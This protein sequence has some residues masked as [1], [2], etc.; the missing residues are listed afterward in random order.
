MLF[1]KISR[2][3]ADSVPFRVTTVSSRILTILLAV[4]IAYLIILLV[5]RI[6]EPRL[7]FFPN[8]PDRMAGN[9]HPRDLPVEDV[10][11][12]TSDGVKLH[13][14]WIGSNEAEYTFLA[15]HGN[16]S[17]I[18]NRVNV[19]EFLHSIPVNVLAVEYRGYGKSEGRPSERGMYLDAEAG[20]NYLS[21][22]KKTDPRKIISYG[23]SLG[24][25][26]AAQLAT[27]HSLEGVVLEAP[28]PS[29]SAMAHRIFPFLPGTS[30]VT[31]RQFDTKRALASIHAPILIVHCTRDPVVP[32]DMGEEVFSLANPPKSI[33]RVN[34][35]CHEE[36]S[37]VDP[38]EYRDA[39]NTFLDEVKNGEAEPK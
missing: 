4:L 16:A 19:Y 6:F 24:S 35:D 33:L 31:W 28:F 8:V 30:I 18:A 38:N 1:G 5:V 2:A 17:N 14:W 10:W 12:E 21:S 26:V 25:A 3:F 39:L 22:T 27:G 7:I 11:L 13:G 29:L 36:A 9:W 15:F 37:F 23:Q 34:G 32:P 20:L